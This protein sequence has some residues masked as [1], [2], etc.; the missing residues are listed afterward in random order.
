MYNV[1]QDMAQWKTY[2]A[3]CA[4]EN[5][6]GTCSYYYVVWCSDSFSMY[7]CDIAETRVEI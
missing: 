7:N 1:W 4:P 6:T 2:V 3:K 5:V